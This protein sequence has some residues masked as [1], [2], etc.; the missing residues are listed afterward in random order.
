MLRNKRNR[1]KSVRSEKNMKRKITNLR[2]ENGITLIAL[3]ITIL[4]LIILA[5]V[6]INMAF[7]DNG[8]IN[9]AEEA[10]DYYANDTA[11]TDE[12]ISNVDSYISGVLGKYDATEQEPTPIASLIEKAESEEKE[13]YTLKVVDDSADGEE[14]IFYIPGGFYLGGLDANKQLVVTTE[15]D[16]GIVITDGTNEFVWVPVDSTSIAEMYQTEDTDTV[17]LPVTLSKSSL[18]EETTTTNVYSKLRIRTG[19][20]YTAGAPGT[21][22]VREPDI[23]TDATYGDAVQNNDTRGINLIRSTFGY[24]DSTDAGVL[25]HFAQDMIN[26]YNATYE[27][28]KKYGG[29]YIGRYE[30]TETDGKP[31]VQRKQPVLTAANENYTTWYG[32]KKACSEVVANNQYAQSEMIYGNQWD[33]VMDWLKQTAFAETT[34]SNPVDVDSSSWGNYSN[35]S[36]E[37]VEGAE[38]GSPRNAGS[39]DAWSANNIYDLAGNYFDWTQEAYDT[40]RRVVRRWQL[41][42]F[43]FW[44][45]SCRSWHLQSV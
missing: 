18:N 32:L 20:Y 12:S 45:S 29:F 27:S 6:A 22:N 2:K 21:T 26:E 40:Y 39:N 3:V 34:G 4:V 10:G 44:Q 43:W 35:Y 38:S 36:G 13:E 16:E 5:V 14:E 19:G 30:L 7:G 41:R 23:L 42:H 11:Y 33:E 9:R 37:E 31:T 15:V 17:T 25:K 24:K 8:L 28:I 1:G